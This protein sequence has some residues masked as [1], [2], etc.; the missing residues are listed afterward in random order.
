MIR[1]SNSTV[2]ERQQEEKRS[3]TNMMERDELC[4]VGGREG[5]ESDFFLS[6]PTPHPSS[7]GG[8]LVNVYGK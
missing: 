6:C 2:T 4:N 3:V 7:S 5:V 1:R 8:G